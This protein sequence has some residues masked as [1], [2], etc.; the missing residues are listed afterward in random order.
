[1][2]TLTSCSAMAGVIFNTRLV[3]IFFFLVASTIN[4]FN[5]TFDL[6]RL[7]LAVTHEIIIKLRSGAQH[8]D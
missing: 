7:V 6:S 4:I 1:M 2:I 8:D 5:V 3:E